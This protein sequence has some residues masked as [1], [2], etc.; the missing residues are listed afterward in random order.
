MDENIQTPE[1]QAPDKIVELICTAAGCNTKVGEIA[2]P[3]DH[4]IDP[5]N[6]SHLDLGF[7]DVRCEEH[8]S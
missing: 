5:E 7:A 4:P 2:F 3:A 6:V 8:P 1:E